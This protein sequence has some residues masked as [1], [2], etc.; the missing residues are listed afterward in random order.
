VVGEERGGL[1]VH[2]QHAAVVRDAHVE[3][4]ADGRGGRVVHEETDLRLGGGREQALEV[5]V[6]AEV[7]RQRAHRRR[8]APPAAGPR[9]PRAAR[10]PRHEEQ[11]EPPPGERLGPG[12]PRP[13]EA[14]A[15]S[16]TGP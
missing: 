13:S 6:A 8:R 14:P 12:G 3:E 5:G 4:A 9:S 11:I 15:T 2:R 1:A 16:A 10:A 7:E